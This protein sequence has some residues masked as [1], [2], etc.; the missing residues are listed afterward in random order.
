M[1]GL[2]RVVL[3]RQDEAAAMGNGRTSDGEASL[4][5]CGA[6][7]VIVVVVTN[8]WSSSHHDTTTSMIADLIPHLAVRHPLDRHAQ[9]M[10]GS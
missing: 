8:P 7:I 6:V 1:M 3:R 9:S 5:G 4:H 2:A 10:H